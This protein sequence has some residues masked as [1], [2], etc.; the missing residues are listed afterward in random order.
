[1]AVIAS[2][3]SESGVKA[4]QIAGI[5]ITNQRETVVVWDKHTGLPVYHAL[6][7]QSRQTAGICEELKSRGFDRIFIAK[8]DYSLIPTFLAPR[9]NGYSTT[10]KEHELKRS[11][12]FAVWY[13]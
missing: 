4:S 2:C 3:L 12:G 13:D 7:W 1:M 6:V 11:A 9:S 10:S 8:R 5:G